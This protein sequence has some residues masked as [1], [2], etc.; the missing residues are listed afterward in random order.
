MKYVELTDEDRQ[1]ISDFCEIAEGAFAKVLRDHPVPFG[2]LYRE[3]QKRMSLA[4]VMKEKI[5][6]KE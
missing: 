5:L 3:G 2:P 4:S 1:L 6:R